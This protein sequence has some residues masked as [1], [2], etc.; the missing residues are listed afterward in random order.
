MTDTKTVWICPEPDCDEP[1]CNACHEP[2]S[3]SDIC[4][5]C[6]SPHVRYFDADCGVEGRCRNCAMKWEHLA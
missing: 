1:A 4:P 5:F 6:G 3:E 2:D